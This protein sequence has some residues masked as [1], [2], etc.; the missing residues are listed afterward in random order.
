MKQRT[1][2]TTKNRRYE[3]CECCQIKLPVLTLIFSMNI[4]VFTWFAYYIFRVQIQCVSVT[5]PFWWFD[6]FDS[7]IMDDSHTFRVHSH[8]NFFSRLVL[9][10][11]WFVVVGCFHFVSIHGFRLAQ[12]SS[13]LRVCKCVFILIRFIR[14]HL[15]CTELGFSSKSKFQRISRPNQIS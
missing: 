9:S 2:A 12:L 7:R 4:I 14:L 11:F 10:H 5:L 8:H 3:K 1:R 13:Y 6:T 15:L